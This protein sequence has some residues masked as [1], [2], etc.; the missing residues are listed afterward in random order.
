[1]NRLRIE[2]LEEVLAALNSDKPFRRMSREEGAIAF[3]ERIRR[4][5]LSHEDPST[6]V[7]FQASGAEQ[8]QAS[9]D[10]G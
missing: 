5:H 7:R 1:M 2:T 10:A 9:D 6:P 3:V 4:E 8:N